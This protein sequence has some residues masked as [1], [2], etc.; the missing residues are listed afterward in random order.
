VNT[1][2]TFYQNGNNQ[3]MQVGIAVGGT[4]TIITSSGSHN[5]FLRCGP[6]NKALNILVLAAAAP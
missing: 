6:N 2:L 3:P 5:L 1:D 4:N